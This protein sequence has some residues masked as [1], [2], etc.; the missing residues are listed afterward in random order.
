MQ[1]PFS[2]PQNAGA[3]PDRRTLLASLTGFQ[4][5]STR[6]SS[7]QLGITAAPSLALIGFM[8]FAYYHI[9]PWLSLA[10]ALPTAGFVV[11]LFIIQHDCGHGSYFH[12]R[13]ANEVVGQLCSLTTFT[14]YALWRRHHANHH[15][16]W[17]NLDKR[18]TGGD[19]YSGCLTVREYQ[20]LSPMR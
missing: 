4:T 17:N 1:S 2:I 13:W 12:A 14:P 8:Y 7:T 19:I 16:V 9:S 11:R 18:P 5:P 6:R 3:T 20:A 15:A 10:L